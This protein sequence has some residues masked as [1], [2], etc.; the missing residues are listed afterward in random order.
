MDEKTEKAINDFRRS[1]I[2]CKLAIASVMAKKRHILEYKR[3][4]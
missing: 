4:K 2:N 1:S 3:K